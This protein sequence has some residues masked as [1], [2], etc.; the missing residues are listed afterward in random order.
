V[1]NDIKTL[2][3]Q[4]GFQLSQGY[5]T[6]HAGCQHDRWYEKFLTFSSLLIPPVNAKKDL[7]NLDIIRVASDLNSQPEKK[8]YYEPSPYL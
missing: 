6:H 1:V 3:I 5:S 4:N 8:L 2:I 7:R